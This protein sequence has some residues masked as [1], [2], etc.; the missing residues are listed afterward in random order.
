[1]RD[2]Q[3]SL[4]S[5]LFSTLVQLRGRGA[6][7]QRA[8]GVTSPQQ[9]THSPVL[10]AAE[11]AKKKKN[12]KTC[13]IFGLRR[14]SPQLAQ[15]RLITLYMTTTKVMGRR[16]ELLSGSAQMGPICGMRR[17]DRH[18]ARNPIINQ[19]CRQRHHDTS[20]RRRAADKQLLC[21]FRRKKMA[22]AA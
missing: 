14:R 18:D 20:R 7:P 4:Q 2:V 22:G 10:G 1:M 6:R 8:I 19:C 9:A 13:Q 16:T 17:T 21:R 5:E 11:R 12:N 15:R 3:S